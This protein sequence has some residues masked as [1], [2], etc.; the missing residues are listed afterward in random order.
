M[1][2]MS[3]AIGATRPKRTYISVM[4]DN[5]ISLGQPKGMQAVTFGCRADGDALRATLPR[6][7]PS[8]WHQKL[9]SRLVS[10]SR[11]RSRNYEQK[12][13]NQISWENWTIEFTRRSSSS[14]HFNTIEPKSTWPLALIYQNPT[15]GYL[16]EANGHDNGP[17]I[18]AWWA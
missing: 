3:R 4:E 17:H 2:K 18:R 13:R 8:T 16:T 6:K 7:K 5:F 12:N 1:T 14:V 10:S 9:R 15:S 11:R